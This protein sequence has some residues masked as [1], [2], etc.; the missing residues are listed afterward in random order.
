MSGRCSGL[1]L[2]KVWRTR[3]WLTDRNQRAR[4]G[5]Q[6]SWAT[7]ALADAALADGLAAGDHVAAPR[8]EEGRTGGPPLRSLLSLA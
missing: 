6:P 2:S 8:H 7:M 3:S 4:T 5:D 1:S